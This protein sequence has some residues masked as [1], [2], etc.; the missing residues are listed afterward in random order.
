VRSENHP[1]PQLEDLLP[2]LQDVEDEDG[3]GGGDTQETE[4]SLTCE[5]SPGLQLCAYSDLGFPP[6]FFNDIFKQ[7]TFLPDVVTD[8]PSSHHVD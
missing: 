7:V 4:S 3:G 2:Y 6:E 8:L 1:Q 5:A